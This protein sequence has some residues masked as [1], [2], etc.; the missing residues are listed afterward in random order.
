M[1]AILHLRDPDHFLVLAG[2]T[3]TNAQVYDAGRLAVIPRTG[4]QARFTGEVLLATPAGSQGAKIIVRDRDYFAP[5]TGPADKLAH[6]FAFVNAGTSDLVVAVNDR[7]CGCTSANPHTQTVRP[8]ATGS[9]TI[10]TSNPGGRSMSVVALHT[11]DPARPRVIL[12]LRSEVPIQV[13]SY[14][15]SIR[16]FAQ[17]GEGKESVVHVAGADRMRLTR[18]S[19]S[20]RLLSVVG[21]TTASVRAGRSL[22]DVT[23]RLSGRAP[24]GSFE[25]MLRIET[26]DAARPVV[27]VPV[28]CRVQG[29]IE[30]IP[31]EAFFGF[32]KVG[33]KAGITLSLRSRSGKAFE[34]REVRTSAP[35][36]HAAWLPAPDSVLKVEVKLTKPG[37][38]DGWVELTTDGPGQETIRVPVSGLVE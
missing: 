7:S 4:I 25:D 6:A 20:H 1:P 3:V 32:V 35:E 29:D 8:G 33:Q 11:N 9:V 22:W 15:Q 16:L 19:L 26:S 31:A 18:A 21:I 17:I 12:T 36:V 24:A 23:V 10:E 34:V 13:S 5:L 37:P 27:T 38:I 2:A 14:P 28:L 30:I